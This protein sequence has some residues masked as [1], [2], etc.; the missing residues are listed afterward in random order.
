MLNLWNS[1]VHNFRDPGFRN[2]YYYN[3]SRFPIVGDFIRYQDSMNYWNDYFRN[4]PGAGG[5]SNVKYPSM[6]AGAGNIS[7][8]M[9]RASVGFVSKNLKSLYR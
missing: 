9:G 5:W 7:G 1:Q 8:G 3:M 4:R 6:M 2:R